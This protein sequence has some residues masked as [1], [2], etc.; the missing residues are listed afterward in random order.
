MIPRTLAQNCG[1]NAVRLLTELRAKHAANPTQ[2]VTFGIDGD[3]GVV[4]DMK[5]LGIV[6]PL[7]VKLQTIKTAIEAACLL[8]RV[9]DIVSG[10]K[11]KGDKD[12]TAT[13]PAPAADETD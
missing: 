1:A 13:Q 5:A 11:K 10:T 9:D 4:A 6:E 7:V 8:L 12:S 3:K 2:N